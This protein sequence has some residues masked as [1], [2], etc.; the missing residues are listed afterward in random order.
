MKRKNQI[1]LSISIL[2]LAFQLNGQQNDFTSHIAISTGFSFA[3]PV[4]PMSKYL[5]EQGF[6]A[7]NVDSWLFGPIDYPAKTPVG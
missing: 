6:D 4:G 7:Q 3:G 1:Y 2:L 5:I